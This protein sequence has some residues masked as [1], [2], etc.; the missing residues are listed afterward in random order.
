[1]KARLRSEL[2]KL[3]PTWTVPSVFGAM[4]ALV[5]L[6]VLLHTL[7]LPASKLAS[8]SSSHCRH[9]GIH[10]EVGRL[11]IEPTGSTSEAAFAA[12]KPTPVTSSPGVQLARR[13]ASMAG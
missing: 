12:R 5:T 8:G 11:A 9:V 1:M 6:A 4:L 2:Y 3:R 7:S 10:Q 13:D